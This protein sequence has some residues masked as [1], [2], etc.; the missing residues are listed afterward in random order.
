M[1]VQLN[2]QLQLKLKIDHLDY[3]DLL[4]PGFGEPLF[5]S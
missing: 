5:N 1:S 4:Q 3:I 2:L